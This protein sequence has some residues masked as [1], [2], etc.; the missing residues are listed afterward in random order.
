MRKLGQ[1]MRDHRLR[2]A[3][4]VQKSVRTVVPRDVERGVKELATNV[5]A[6][7]QKLVKGELG[8]NVARDMDKF[9]TGFI[10]C[11]ALSAVG[12]VLDVGCPW[13]CVFAL[14][15]GCVCLHSLMKFLQPNDQRQPPSY[16][17]NLKSIT[18]SCRRRSVATSFFCP[19]LQGHVQLDSVWPQGLPVGLLPADWM[20]VPD[21]T[22]S[23]VAVCVPTA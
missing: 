6:V 9:L 23:P 1:R 2:V 15:H 13:L 19:R 18:S 8:Q 21:T 16:T 11:V 5:E 14:S 20:A 17:V 12:W 4:R 3:S 22:Q 10:R 7:M